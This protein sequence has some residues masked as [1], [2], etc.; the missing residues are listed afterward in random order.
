MTTNIIEFDE[1]NFQDIETSIILE[2]NHTIYK[3][4]L[5]LS[6]IQDMNNIVSEMLSENNIHMEI[7]ENNLTIADKNCDK[8]NQKLETAKSETKK[9]IKYM[10]YII[11]SGLIVATFPISSL[12]GIKIGIITGVG[13]LLNIG[14]AKAI[15][16]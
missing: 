10:G 12:I 16:E 14:C 2:N 15:H 5:D 6:N 9:Y 11:G 8:A 4:S 3:L 7:I 1:S 13:G